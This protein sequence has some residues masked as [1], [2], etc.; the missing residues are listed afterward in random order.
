M[1][2]QVERLRILAVTHNYPRFPGDPAGAFVARIAEGAA[3]RGHAVEVIAPHAP[4]T[5]EDERAGGLRV[6]R[7]RYGPELL[8]RVAYTGNLHGR[9]LMSPLAALGFPGFV[10]AFGRAVRSAVRQF[11]PDVIHAHWWMPSGWFTSRCQV[12]YLVTCHGSDVRLLERGS[13]VRA[14]ALPVFH[15]A[16]RVTTVSKF[17][18]DDIQRMLPPLRGRVQV[19]PMPVDVGGF[20]EGA[21]APKVAPPRVLYAGNL[22]PSKGVDVLLRAVA[23]LS[24]RGVACELK[25][26]GEGPARSELEA[27]AHDL[28]IGSKTTWAPFV[29]QGRMAAE[30]GAATVTVLPTRGRAEGLGLT[31]VEALLAGSAVVGTAAGGIPEVVVH[32]Q[33]GL[34]ARDG[35]AADL[36]DQVQRLLTDAVLRERL[37]RAGKEHVLRAFAPEAAIDRFIEIYGAVAKHQPRS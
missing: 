8:E 1:P 4:G 13:V 23:E 30:Y 26:L 12:P 31:L 24:R 29:P 6:R 18:A 35:D 22:V 34:I 19:A 5:A 17:L 14:V 9:T 15:R 25:I 32:E 10:L 16:A 21:R 37:I 7:F 33:T 3:A 20:L 27:L 11:S 2:S 28:G 36:A